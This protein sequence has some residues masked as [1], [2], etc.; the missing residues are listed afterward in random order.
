MEAS[1]KA[2]KKKRSPIWDYFVISD[3]EKWVK[4]RSCELKVSRGG[5]DKNVWNNK[6]INSFESKTSRIV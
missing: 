5:K 1:L 3:D 6:P 2:P 4:C